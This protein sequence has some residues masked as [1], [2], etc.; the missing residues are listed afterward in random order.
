[1]KRSTAL[2]LAIE[3]VR[4]RKTLKNYEVSQKNISK[5]APKNIPK[6]T[7]KNI[8]TNIPKK[9][10]RNIPLNTLRNTLRNIPEE[11]ETSFFEDR[12]ETLKKFLLNIYPLLSVTNVLNIHSR[13][14]SDNTLHSM[15]SYESINFWADLGMIHP[16]IEIFVNYGFNINQDLIT[17][18]TTFS[19]K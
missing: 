2:E 8:P 14:I 3:T 5:K 12:E 17:G 7:Q 9:T 11:Y 18:E 1:M 4:L 16:L 15:L 19:K 6:K 10:Q 13:H